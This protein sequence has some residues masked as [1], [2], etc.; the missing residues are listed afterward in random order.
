MNLTRDLEQSNLKISLEQINTQNALLMLDTQSA[1][2]Q[3]MRIDNEKLTK[4][5]HD[6]D[7]VL[8]KRL[9]KIKD[10]VEQDKCDNKLTYYEAVLL[11]F[12]NE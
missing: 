6:L 10:P 3:Q 5:L 12:N 4:S 1:Q 8:Q 2:L 11:E 7:Q 9:S